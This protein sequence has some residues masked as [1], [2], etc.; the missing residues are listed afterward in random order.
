MSQKGLKGARD[1]TI[2]GFYYDNL[3]AMAEHCREEERPDRLLTAFVLNR[4]FS[5]LAEEL[6]G[7]PVLTDVL[8]KWEV[9]YRNTVNLALEKADAGAPPEEQARF[10]TQL[11][12]LL[13]KEP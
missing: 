3:V 13:W 2:N 5:H 9:R 4:F 6:G 8:R 11:V 10:L 1:L 7:G 12:Q